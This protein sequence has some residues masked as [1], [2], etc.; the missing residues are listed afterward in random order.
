MNY[1][2]LSEHRIA[3]AKIMEPS[4]TNT[5]YSQ[6]WPVEFPDKRLFISMTLLNYYNVLSIFEG[7]Y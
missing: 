1:S 5:A 7:F 2:S 3:Y 6:N 4:T